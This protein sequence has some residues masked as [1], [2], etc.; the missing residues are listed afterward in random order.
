MSAGGGEADLLTLL[1]RAGLFKRFVE[2]AN[3]IFILV[4][5]LRK[6]HVAFPRNK[7]C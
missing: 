1:L 6:D 4:N 3:F 7:I 5:V 2:W